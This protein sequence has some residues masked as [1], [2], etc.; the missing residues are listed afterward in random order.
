VIHGKAYVKLLDCLGLEGVFEENLKAPALAGRVKYLRKYLK[1]TYPEDQRKQF[2]YSLILFTLFVEN[3]SL[4]S[5]FYVV[6]NLNTFKNILKDTA[7]QIQYTKNEETLHGQIGI[8]LINTLRDEY[9]HLFDDELEAR[10]EEEVLSAIEA[11]DAMVDWIVGDYS[12]ERLDAHVLKQFVRR[13]I[14]DSLHQAGFDVKVSVDEDAA[15]QTRWFDEIVLGNGMTDFFSGR[16]I[17]YS[18]SNKVFDSED[19]FD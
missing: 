15:E 8:K 9:P 5:Q 13:R 10:I 1:R 16:P 2:I 3:V 17:E 14:N 7:Q 18:R 4:F 6:L 11:E 12:G 19:L